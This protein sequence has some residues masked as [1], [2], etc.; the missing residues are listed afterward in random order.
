MTNK[1]PI[2]ASEKRHMELDELSSLTMSDDKIIESIYAT[3]VHVHGDHEN[4]D[5]H[6]LFIHVK[7]ILMNATE[8]V[9]NAVQVYI[10]QT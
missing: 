2:I 10:I 9:D 7:N 1:W 8:I 3:H 6:S 5:V 4:F